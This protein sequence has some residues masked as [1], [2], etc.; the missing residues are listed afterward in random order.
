LG[1][2]ARQIHAGEIKH[3]KNLGKISTLSALIILLLIQSAAALEFLY[4]EGEGFRK[5]AYYRTKD[6]RLLFAQ[7]FGFVPA[8][9]PSYDWRMGCSPTSAGMIMGFYD[10]HGHDGLTYDDLV[11][12]VEAEMST[13]GNPGAFANQMIASDGH[14][15][16]FYVQPNAQGDPNPGST[17]PFDCLADFMGT[18]QWTNCGSSDGGTSFWFWADTGTPFTAADGQQ[19]EDAGMGCSGAYGIAEYLVYSGY[20]YAAV[21]NQKIY[22]ASTAPGG[23]TWA[24]Y[25]AEINAGRPVLIH[26]EGHTMAGIGYSDPSTIYLYDTWVSSVKT[27][28]WG[29]SYPYGSQQLAH[30]SVTC[31]EITGG[32]PGSPPPPVADFTAGPLSGSVPLTVDFSDLSSNSPT[33]WEWDMDND[34]NPDRSTQNP[35]FTYVSPGQYSVKLTVSNEGGQDTELKTHYITVTASEC[36]QYPVWNIDQGVTYNSLADAYDDA[37]SYDTLWVHADYSGQSLVFNQNKQVAI[38]GGYDCYYENQI[39]HTKVGSQLVISGG[40]LTAE[41]IALQ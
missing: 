31:I 38:Q 12:G 3:L 15:A 28:T 6:G 7:Q 18:S 2:G 5:K 27:M 21:Y 24:Q 10:I 17:R 9:V 19:V 1:I 22:K 16:D 39:T 32:D 14:D 34:G 29:G 41:Y 40:S 8:D 13:F 23:F 25:K 33:S 4:Q 20:D 35:S 36:D 30:D 26:V 11:P 37:D